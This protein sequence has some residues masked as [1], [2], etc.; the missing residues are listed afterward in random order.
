V[1]FAG[2]VADAPPGIV[3]A[4]SKDMLRRATPVAALLALLGTATQAQ[5]GS[6]AKVLLDQANYWYAQNKPDDAE[7]ALD[8]LLRLEPDNPDALGLLAQLQAERG[9]RAKA[10]ATV[11]HLQTLRPDDPA[12]ARVE[13]AIR[14]GSIDPSGLAEARHLAQ[15]GHNADAVARYQRLFQGSTPPAALAVEY[16]GTLSGTEGGWDAAR[17]GL[18]QVAAAAPRDLRAQLA[19]AQLLTYREPT[20]MEGAQRLAVLAHAPETSAAAAK[21]WRQAL[22]WMPIDT[23]SIPAYQSWLADHAN[24]SGISGRLEQARNPPRAPVDEAA[25]KRATGFTALN[26]GR[27]QDAESAFQAVLVQSPQD[28]DALGG[29]GLVRLRQGNA[30]DARTLLSRAISADPAHKERWESALEGASVGEDYAAARTMIQRGQFDAAERQLR[31]IISS[32]GDVAGAQMMLADVLSRH[33]D[34]PGAETQYRAVLA[35]Q[36]NNADALVGMAR[37]LNQQGHGTEAEALLDRAQSSGNGRTV[38]RIRATALRQQAASTADPAAKEALLRAAS[39]ADPG[40]PWAR[41]DL[42]RVLTASGKKAEAREVMAE[43]TGGSNPGVDALRAGAMFAAE[44]GRPT[45]AATLVGRLPA[46]ARTP[47]MRAL[48]AQAARQNEIRSAM[49]LA[50]V[51]PAAVREKLLTLAAQPDPDGTNGVAVARAF[52]QMRDP[53]GARAALATAQAAT[54][55]PTPSQRIAYAGLLL[56]AGDERGAQILI[57]TLDGTGGLNLEQTTALNRL[58]AGAAIRQSDT[59]NG[60]HLQAAAYDVLA[61]ALA[62]EPSNPDLNL[63][64]ARLYAGADQ[65]RKALAIN[66]A[67]LERDPTNLDARKAALDSAVQ[68]SDWARADGI[69][70]DAIAAAPDDARTWVMS[71]TLD[72]ARGNL[73]RAYDDLKRAQALRR[74]EVGSDAVLAS[75]Q[76]ASGARRYQTA[77]L[78]GSTAAMSPSGNP[79]RRG[80]ADSSTAPA[81][82]DFAAATTTPADPLLQDIDQQI[83]VAQESLAPKFSIGPAFRSRSGTSGLDQ[84]EEVSLPTELVARPLGR[85]ELTMTATPTFLSAGSVPLD[86]DSQAR[87]GTGAFGLHAAPPGQHAEGVGLL[88]TYQLGWAKVDVGT[89]PIGFQQQNLLGGIELSPEIADGVRLRI[90]GERRSVTDSVLSYAGTKDPATGIAWGGVTR[91][92]GHAQ[93]EFSLREANFYAG[94]GYAVLDGENVVSNREYDL[95]A[96]GSYPVWR[97]QDDEVRVG[98]DIVYFGYDKNT[99]FFTLGQG[100][101]FSPQSY[102]ATLIPVKYTV[103][104]DELTWSIGGS[105]GYQTYN[106]HSSV[107]FPTNP[108]FQSA[109]VAEAA[110]LP[111]ALLTSFPG[112]SASGV[113]GGAEGSVEYRVNGSFF[114]GGQATYQHA[115]NWSETIGRLYGRYIFGGGTW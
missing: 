81:M 96:G 109:L 42:A 39:N 40:D 11:A 85:G 102:F 31:A 79:F 21:A 94:G 91:S 38:G 115:G 100:G 107:V 51:S 87:F 83:G 52:L 54:R 72:R 43:V 50:A 20:R 35:R 114:V 29:L 30:A 66:Q 105:L 101:Y 55:V 61:P 22:E 14:V 84:L 15:E 27:V 53:A 90:L 37:V 36:P 12:I 113:V 57:N 59:L 5:T 58:R 111:T 78:T 17:A 8:R 106:E 23:A 46:A 103:K 32:G 86:I 99:D 9:D 33:G 67:V 62:H 16:Y 97:G 24:D 64:V 70:R 47:D 112:Q 1:C 92:R 48:L 45:D 41:L 88:G 82:G 25:L 89:S 65:P 69:V 4:W 108:A 77:A 110:T 68:A 6:A 19:Y 56:Q 7:H 49:G 10:Q 74:Q 80:E 34:L 95:G 73:A 75:D 98:L 13:Q 3:P 2:E 63:A 71:A 76:P 18:A 93:L 28:P 26:A 60:Q 104:T 44:D